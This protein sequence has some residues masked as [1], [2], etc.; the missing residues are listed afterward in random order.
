MPPPL[1][2]NAWFVEF[3]V[4]KHVPREKSTSNKLQLD[5]GA[6]QTIE[7]RQ[8]HAL[9]IVND[10]SLG[11]VGATDEGLQHVKEKPQQQTRHTDQLNGCGKEDGQR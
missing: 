2:I 4:D 9:R 6:E 5:C 3:G 11:S 8:E 7:C 1:K 10:R